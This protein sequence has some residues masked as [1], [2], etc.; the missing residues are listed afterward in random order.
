NHGHLNGQIGEESTQL[1]DHMRRA[2]SRF[3]M[4][5]NK[6]HKRIGKVA[7]DRPKIKSSQEEAYAMQV[8][9]YDHFNPVRAKLIPN[10]THIKWRLFSTAR[11]MAFGEKNEFTCMITLPQWYM[12]LGK[13][14][15]QRQRKYR[16]MLDQFMIDK[17]FKPDPKKTRG[18][19]IGGD[20]WVEAMRNQLRDLMRKKKK[21]SSDDD[22]PDTS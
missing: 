12:R 18:H 3:G 19:F 20:L 15:K 10:P 5:Y 11:Y 4:G 2:H 9:L 13:T 16:Q 17:G 14:D 7:H 22:P 8:M 21:G 6:R 1:S